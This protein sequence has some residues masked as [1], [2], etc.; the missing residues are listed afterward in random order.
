MF[1]FLY[2]CK[3][4]FIPHTKNIILN[5]IVTYIEDFYN[6]VELNI[7]IDFTLELVCWS[8][9]KWLIIFRFVKIMYN[10]V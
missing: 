2:V 5:M 7:K 1:S 8:K 3:L 4:N 10:P 6:R 9:Y